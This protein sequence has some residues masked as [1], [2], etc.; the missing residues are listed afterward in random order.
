MAARRCGLCG[1][2]YP[3]YAGSVTKC[4]IHDED[5]VYDSDLEVDEDWQERAAEIAEAM[6]L[7]EEDDYLVPDLN[8]DALFERDGRT[9]IF[10]WDVV[11]RGINHRLTDGALLRVKEQVYEVL[12][13][14]DSMRAYW[15]QTFRMHLSD[16]DIRDL[17]NPKSRRRKRH[18]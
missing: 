9:F 15:V 4:P 12:G 13:Y 8:A 1:I 2:N 6:A 5:M 18:K 14:I 11:E 7:R 10:A 3:P 17:A 16:K